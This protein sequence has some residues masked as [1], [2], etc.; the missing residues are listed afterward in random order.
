MTGTVETIVFANEADGFVVARLR[1]ESGEAGSVTIVGHM[2]GLAPDQRVSV[3]GRWVAHPQYGA[4]LQVTRHEL[5][6]PSAR[7][8]WPSLEARLAQ[9]LGPILADR[10]LDHFGDA[11]QSILDREPQRLQEVAGIGPRRAER[12]A[13]A[14]RIQR[15]IRDVLSF[16]RGSGIDTAHAVEIF[17]AYGREAPRLLREDP[18]RLANEGVGMRFPTADRIALKMGVAPAAPE[19]IRAALCHTLA[20]APDGHGGFAR[21]ELVERCARLIDLDPTKDRDRLERELDRLVAA[22]GAVTER[23][24][25]QVKP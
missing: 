3:Y 14:W 8:D 9:E 23:V 19:R 13:E 18:Y 7:G 24:D 17:Q 20:A 1:P 4:Q 12:I 2:A 25:A 5:E 6:Q 21:E 22:G 16:L 15:E 10:I 11:T